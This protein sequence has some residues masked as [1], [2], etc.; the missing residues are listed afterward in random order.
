[1]YVIHKT[2]TPTAA[3]PFIRSLLASEK[4]AHVHSCVTTVREGK[5]D[6]C[7][8]MTPIS[9]FSALPSKPYCYWVSPE[10][11]RTIS[12]LPKLEGNTGTVRVGLQTSDDFRFLRLIWE[13]PAAMVAPSPSIPKCLEGE[14]LQQECLKELSSGKRWAFYSKTDEAKPWL[15]PLTLVVDWENAG[16]RIKDYARQQGN[17]PSRSVRSEDRYFQAG[18]SYML[19]SVAHYALHRS[20]WSDTYGRQG[21]GLSSSKSDRPDGGTFLECRKCCGSF[22]GRVVCTP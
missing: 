7:V 11:L 16:Q 18:F 15:S 19:R 9:A 14:A 17:S 21:T 10:T 4:A 3:T 2:H 5:A 20:R 12:A 22:P 6:S 8:F 1:M 13:V